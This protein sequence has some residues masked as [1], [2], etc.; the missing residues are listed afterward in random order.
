M[1]HH[2]TNFHSNYYRLKKFEQFHDEVNSADVSPNSI[3]ELLDKINAEVSRDFKE[4]KNDF[5]AVLN[6]VFPNSNFE[7]VMFVS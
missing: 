6:T 3:L 5:V 4:C 7:K 2:S 1:R